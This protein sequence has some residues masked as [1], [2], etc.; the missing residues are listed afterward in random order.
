ML[1]KRP[2]QASGTL[3]GGTQETKYE[4]LMCIDKSKNTIHVLERTG[5]KDKPIFYQMSRIEKHDG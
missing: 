3:L 4:G 1:T 5:E 2:K